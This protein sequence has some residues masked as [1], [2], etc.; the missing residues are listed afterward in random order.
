MSSGSRSSR[1]FTPANSN[2]QKQHND[3]VAKLSSSDYEDGTYDLNTLTQVSYDSGYQVTFS[4]IGDNYS[5]ADYADKVNEF[6]AVSSDGKTLAGK[7]EG[8]PEVSF[9]CN[10]KQTAINLAKKY[11]Q[12]SIWDWGNC[13]EIKTGGTGE[14]S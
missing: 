3:A 8:T 9:H 7:F 4:Q 10:D 14:R 11:N 13:D 1:G 12:I 5:P 6:L 2:T